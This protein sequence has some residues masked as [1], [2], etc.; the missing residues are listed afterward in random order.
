MAP[1]SNKAFTASLLTDSFDPA[2]PVAISWNEARSAT[3]EP[4]A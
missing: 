1:E 3:A 4:A 2:A